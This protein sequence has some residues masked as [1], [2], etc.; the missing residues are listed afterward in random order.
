MDVRCH[1]YV[2]EPTYTGT[3]AYE[4]TFLND[5]P[6]VIQ[7][8]LHLTA[9]HIHKASL[10][11]KWLT[12]VKTCA[13]EQHGAYRDQKANIMFPQTCRGGKKVYGC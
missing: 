3:N 5:T 8:T 6:L 2:C 12:P 4:P 7:H 10:I 13:V 1:C 9:S 11:H